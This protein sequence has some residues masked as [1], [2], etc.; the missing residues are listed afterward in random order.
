MIYSRT[1]NTLCQQENGTTTCIYFLYIYSSPSIDTMKY[2]PLVHA[3]WLEKVKEALAQRQ[4]TDAKFTNLY[5]QTCFHSCKGCRT[6]Q[7]RGDT[8][9]EKGYCTYTC[10]SFVQ[11]PSTMENENVLY[12]TVLGV[13]IRHQK[14]K[15]I[16]T[17]SP[18]FSVAFLT[19]TAS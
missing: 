16:T 13:Q 1:H 12:I 14:S 5:Y 19:Y 3:L 4:N 11:S 17:A 9:G 2:K 15:S 8:A 10:V 7:L 18:A 6:S